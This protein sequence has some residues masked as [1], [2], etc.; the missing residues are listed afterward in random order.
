VQVRADEAGAAGDQTRM[1]ISLR[2][3]VR[4]PGEAPVG[5]VGGEQVLDVVHHAV[6]NAKGAN[7]SIPSSVN[8]RWATARITAW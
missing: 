8:W 4:S 3:L 5:L 6:G 2:G 1:W 7:L